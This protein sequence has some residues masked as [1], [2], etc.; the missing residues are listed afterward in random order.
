MR[1]ARGKAES[2]QFTSRLLLR[3]GFGIVGVV[4]FSQ[5][6]LLGIRQ[7]L[8]EVYTYESKLK[9]NT[10]AA[11]EAEPALLKAIKYNPHNGYAHYFLG[12]FYQRQGRLDEAKRELHRAL[13]TMAHPATPLRLLAENAY[14]RHAYDDAVRH[15]LSSLAMNPKPKHTASLDWYLFAK[16]C[17]VAGNI[18]QAITAMKMAQRYGAS[19]SDLH[20]VLGDYYLQLGNSA[21]ALFEYL[22]D[23]LRHPEDEA[24]FA[25]LIKFGE[26]TGDYTRALAF[27][28][29]RYDAGQLSPDGVAFLGLLYYLKKDYSQALTLLNEAITSNPTEARN[30]YLRGEVYRA[31]GN[32]QQMR[33]DYQ[34]YLRL[35]P[36][37][38]ERA[39]IEQ[40]LK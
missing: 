11:Y 12:A 19:Q 30:Y 31:L 28:K 40:D 34:A 21:L 2:R 1:Q 24:A 29:R 8:S 38:P 13:Q 14:S 26:K 23:Y 7:F 15:F 9:I 10:P 39:Y 35:A 22:T 17:A 27:F 3:I 32:T 33:E 4:L 6:V 5:L 37:A 20:L 18:P 25:R 36:A 16:A